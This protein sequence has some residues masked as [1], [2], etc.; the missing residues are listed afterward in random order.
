MISESHCT[1]DGTVT[2]VLSVNRC[3]FNS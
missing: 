3:L 2:Q 1:Y